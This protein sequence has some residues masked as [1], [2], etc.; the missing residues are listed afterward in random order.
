ASLVIS[1][2]TGPIH[3]ATGQGAPVIGLY[4]PNTPALYGARG[5][6]AMA[7]Y[8][9][10]P[11]S[12]CMTNVNEKAS[13]CQNNI[14][15]TLITV[16]Q[17]IKSL[18]PKFFMYGPLPMWMLNAVMAVHDRMFDPLMLTLKHDQIAYMVIGR[19]I[20]AALGTASVPLAYVIA[21]RA[22]GRMAGLIAAF[23][24]AV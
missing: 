21:R 5:A 19:A 10:L 12:P 17:V 2:D 8:L 11:C 14:C 16:D 1:N 23:L 3:L 13:D 24:L 9:G 22:G 20:S 7:F 6:H 18:S 4:G 15:M